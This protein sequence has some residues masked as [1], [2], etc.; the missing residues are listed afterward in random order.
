MKKCVNC[1]QELPDEAAYCPHCET[2]QI[3]KRLVEPPK[4]RRG[5]AAAAVCA[6]VLIAAALGAALA[7]GGWREGDAPSP[8]APIPAASVPAESMPAETAGQEDGLSGMGADMM[9]SSGGS[10]Y[11]LMLV[12]DA[13]SD[14]VQ[15]PQ[16]ERSNTCAEGSW[17]A[18]PSQLY[19]YNAADN[20]PANG[21]FM[22]LVDGCSVEALPRG[23]AAQMEYTAPAADP[24]FPNAAMVSHISFTYGCGTND[25]LWTLSMKNG[26]TVQ[27]CQSITVIDLE[28]RVFTPEDTAME[29]TEELQSLMDYIDRE[30]PL[31][32]AVDIYLPPVAY[33]GEL[34]LTMRRGVSLFG[35]SDDGGNATTFTGGVTV[36]S[37]YMQLTELIGI[38]FEGSGGTAV[39][40]GDGVYMDNCTFTGWDTAAL[41]LDGAWI[42]AAGCVFERNGT[43]LHFNTDST[44]HY[45]SPEYWNNAFMDNG[46]AILIDN[47]PGDE[48]L[49][50]PECVFSGNDVDIDNP[51]GHPTDVSGAKFY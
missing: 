17:A 42:G 28:T 1:G 22:E 51:A 14:G 45:S 48:V 33:S 11:R 49:R 6:S 9:Y 41:A 7:A 13:D 34:S 21:E 18:N 37:A 36:R 44:E 10:S 19:V 47:L 2:S 50:F 24:S 38:R 27:L 39:T 25:I 29:T 43:A 26:D 8:S 3:E 15:V 4:R 20:S 16:A 35:S 12:I 23:G 32:T 5:A 30:V 46:T 31:D 40:A